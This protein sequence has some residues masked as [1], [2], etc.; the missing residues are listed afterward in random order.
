MAS[1]LPAVFAAFVALIVSASVA[2]ADIGIAAAASIARSMYPG[3]PLMGLVHRYQIGVGGF[4]S[5]TVND[6]TNTY[7]YSVDMY[8]YNGTMF[9]WGMNFV[10][11]QIAMET[12]PVLERLPLVT[13][14][15]S[16]AVNRVR[17]FTG[18][19]DGSIKN[20]SLVSALFMIFYDV[21]YN[22]TYRVMVDAITGQV[23][24]LVDTAT[25]VNSITPAAY[26]AAVIRAE[27]LAGPGWYPIFGETAATQTGM[28]VGIMMLNPLTGNVKQVDM[29][30][31]Q[32]DVLEFTP[33]GSLALK[34]SGIR[35]QWPELQI[36][37]ELLLDKINTI[38]PGSKVAN[39]GLQAQFNNG[40]NILNWNASVLTSTLQ[41]LAVIFNAK[42]P[43][44]FV[45]PIATV[46]VTYKLGD[47]NQDGFVNGDDLSQLLTT[48]NTNYPPYDLNHDGW[49][50]GEDLAILL[51]NWG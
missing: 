18:R 7:Q 24:P 1:R 37:A 20:I 43:V 36:T 19:P 14:D 4:Y 44:G 32:S 29:L 17:E 3:K 35:G 27:A 49:V 38:Y 13:I 11:D 23:V 33:I 42:M 51:Q 5:A 16:D 26:K 46:P 48:F 41:P 39:F 22:D 30:N 40:Q 47:Y 9:G 45:V 10:T 12:A 8:D 6:W 2:S 21:R 28:A 34:V 31:K 15:Y 50:R 25:A